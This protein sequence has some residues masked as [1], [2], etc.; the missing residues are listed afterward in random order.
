MCRVATVSLERGR[1]TTLT[2]DVRVRDLEVSAYTIPTEQPEADG[3]LAWSETV[4]IVVEPL[5]DSGIRGLGYTYGTPAVASLIRDKLRK[6]IVGRDV[7]DVTGAWEA[8]VRSIRNLGRPGLCS[9]AI[10]AVDIAL[11][12]TKA[13]AADEPLHHLLGAVREEV[14]VYGSGGFTSYTDK[15]LVRQLRGWVEE[16][17][18]RVKMKIGMDRGASWRRDLQRVEKVR[19]AIG[20]AELFVDAN[21]GYDRTQ[22]RRLGEDY[23]RMGVT[24]FEEPVSSDDLDGLAQ[25]RSALP[26]DVTAGEYGYHLDYFRWMLDAGAVDVMQADI[27]RCAGIT[28]WLRVAALCAAHQTP[29]S[30]H[31][32]PALHAH[33]ACV[34]PNLRHIEYFHDH[35]RVDHMLFDGVLEPQDGCLRPTARAGLGLTLRREEAERYRTAV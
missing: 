25:L 35:V 28:E 1:I 2:G 17:I 30:A 12:D 26:L 10:A 21:G 34:P 22:A 29:F 11:W 33:A 32:A 18:P 7:R 8:M 6:E 20:D 3:T 23:A 5:L 9:M 13:R 31:C 27:S 19:A 15:E 4:V 14:P 24:W 16:G